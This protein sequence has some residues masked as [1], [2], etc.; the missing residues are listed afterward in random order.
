MKNGRS[1][2]WS[3]RDCNPGAPGGRHFLRPVERPGRPDEY[4]KPAS[5]TMRE[6]SVSVI[7]TAFNV[8]AYICETIDSILTQPVDDLEVIVVDDGSTD[9]TADVLGRYQ[10]VRRVRVI[11]QPN[12]GSASARNTGARGAVGELLAFL[13]GDDVATERRIVAPVEALARGPDIALAYGRI[14]LINESGKVLVSRKNPARYRSGWVAKDL[15]YRNFIPFSTITVRR[16]VFWALGGFDESIRSSEDWEFLLRLASRH[17]VAFVDEC[18]VRYRVRADSKTMD[19]EAKERAIRAV[20]ERI[21]C[22]P[23]S[24][25]KR[26]VLPPLAD[27]CRWMGLAGTL[28]KLGEM[29]RACRFFLR[30]VRCHP[31]VLVI[32]RSEIRDGLWRVLSREAAPMNE[33]RLCTCSPRRA[34]SKGSART[35][36]ARTVKRI[37]SHCVRQLHVNLGGRYAFTAA[38]GCRFWLHDEVES[39]A[40]WIDSG[41]PGSDD[42]AIFLREYLH[43]G[44]TFADVGANIGRYTIL[45]SR[46]VGPRGKVYAFEPVPSVFRALQQNLR[47]NRCTNVGAFCLAIAES[48]GFIEF[49]VDARSSALN[50]MFPR[51][52]RH[53]LKEIRCEAV[54]GVQAMELMGRRPIDVLKIDVEGAEL[55]VLRSFGAGLKETGC[56]LF[57]CSRANFGR[58][59][60]TIRDLLTQLQRTGHSLFELDHEGR[61]F[62]VVNPRVYDTV[63]EDLIAVRR[64]AILRERVCYRFA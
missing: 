14:D 33:R 30:A 44:D 16:D 49:W 23:P 54:S 13:D 53:D 10:R 61:Q 57:E 42:L 17:P 21:F 8:E 15:R 37:L 18:L 58:A 63:N 3:D 47:L 12:A 50:S 62:C 7:V 43:E 26:R 48:E 2:R 51:A 28:V 34:M 39:H 11:R 5:D 19:V 9:G 59:G 29:R 41:M 55:P 31:G 27:A 24:S 22:N 4:S 46:L 56:I 20:Q 60:Y 45:A 38:D 52:G 6:P 35:R 32:F 64:P 25:E 1:P 36:L 40:L